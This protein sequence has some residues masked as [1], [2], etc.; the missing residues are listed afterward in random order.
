M[1][2]NDCERLSCIDYGQIGHNNYDQMRIDDYDCMFNIDY[3]HMGHDDYD[4]MG[5]LI[6]TICVMVII[7][8]IMFRN[9]VYVLII[10]TNVLVN[11]LIYLN[12][13]HLFG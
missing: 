13:L 8:F 10:M 1:G 4:C 11:I 7:S 12:C 3:D 2:L 6:M 9:I 5:I